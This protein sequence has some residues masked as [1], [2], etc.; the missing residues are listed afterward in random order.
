LRFVLPRSHP[1]TGVGQGIFGVAYDLREGT[2]VSISD[3]QSLEGLLAWFA[4]N[5]AI[6]QRFDTSKSKGYY[7]RKTGGISWLKPTAIEY[8]AKM[9]ALVTI[10]DKN[11]YQVAQITT[12]RRDMSFSKMTIKPS[13]NRFAA[14]KNRAS[15]LSVIAR[16]E[17]T[18]QSMEAQRWIASLRSQ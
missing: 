6:P 11:G 12:D 9:R 1:D 2:L 13:Q 7:R 8:I 4:A 15:M 14:T 5:L 3:R 17:A 18:K 16:S 10:L